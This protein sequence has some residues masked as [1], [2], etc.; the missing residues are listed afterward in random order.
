MVLP[1]DNFYHLGGDSIT[2]IHVSCKLNAKGLSLSTQII[3]ARPIIME[4]AS[5]IEVNEA[6]LYSEQG[7]LS[8]QIEPTPITFWFR[9]FDT[10]NGWRVYAAKCSTILQFGK[11]LDR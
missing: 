1:E 7:L 4:M 2:A 3:L 5:K 6:K 11:N 10:M 9:G 8:G